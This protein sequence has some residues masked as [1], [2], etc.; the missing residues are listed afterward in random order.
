MKRT[1]LIIAI[2][3][4]NVLF[5]DPIEP[6]RTHSDQTFEENHDFFSVTN[7]YYIPDQTYQYLSTVFQDFHQKLSFNTSIKNSTFQKS[8]YNEIV[9][10]PLIADNKY[11]VQF[12]LFGN[13]A[14][15]DTS[16]LSNLPS[17]ITLYDYY[18]DNGTFELRNSELTLGAGFSFHTSPTTS[19]KLIISDGDLPGYG[20]SNALFGVETIF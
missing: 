11:G 10:L 13:L 19:L 20:S 7:F 3:S 6:K 5:A 15:P 1:L 9:S 14:D 8:N 12:E 17:D 18:T 4:T 16:Y 2:F